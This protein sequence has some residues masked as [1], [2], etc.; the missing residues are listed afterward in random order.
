M[1]LLIKTHKPE[2]EQYEYIA[3]NLDFNSRDSRGFH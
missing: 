2:G 1:I 3:N